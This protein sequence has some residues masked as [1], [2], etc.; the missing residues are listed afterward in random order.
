MVATSVAGRGLDVPEIVAVVNYNCPNHM[1][2]ASDEL[3]R[4]SNKSEKWKEAETFIL[5]SLEQRKKLWDGVLE[6]IQKS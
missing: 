4:I 5:L 3:I 6:A 1:E 2:V